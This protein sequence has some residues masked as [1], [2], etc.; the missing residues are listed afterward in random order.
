[1]KFK[2]I[3]GIIILS[4]LLINPLFAQNFSPPEAKKIPE[5]FVLHGHKRI[6]NYFWLRNK[7][8]PAV[9]DYLKAENEYVNSYMEDT[10]VLQKKLFEEFKAR[11]KKTD[12]SVPVKKGS[13][14]YYTR[15]EADKEYT[16]YCRKKD[17]MLNAEEVLLDLNKLS[18]KYDYFTLGV[19][20]VS[21]DHRF[22]A[23]SIDTDGSETHTLMI[24]DLQSGENL[25]EKIPNTYYSVEW[26]NDSKTIYYNVLDSAKRPF[27]LYRHRLGQNSKNDQLIYQED[28]A[29]Y[30]LNLYKTKSEKYIVISLGSLTT[31][32][33]HLLNANIPEASPK[34][35]QPR[36]K[37][38]EYSIVHWKEHFFILTNENAENYKILQ[39]PA[40]S[41]QKSNWKPFISHRNEVMLKE[42]EVF[43]NYLVMYERY[44]GLPHIR[45]HDLEKNE[46]F[47]IDFPE[48][49]YTYWQGSNPDI[50]SHFLRFNYTS[51]TTPK[52]VYDYDLKNRK[53]IIKKQRQIL[54]YE[55]DL[56]QTDRIFATADDGTKIPISLV[57]KKSLKKNNGNPLFL[58]AYGAYGSISDPWF[59]S[60]LISL[61]D[62]GF[63]YAIA[64]IRGGGEMGESWYKAG[65][66]LN[67]K[68]SFSD[69]IK[70]A[71]HLISSGYTSKEQLVIQGVSAGGLLMG[72]VTNMRP[73]LFKAVIAKVP[74]VDALNTM[75]DPSLPLTVI[76]YDE[77]GN[78]QEKKYYDYIKT[79]S[80]YDNIEKKQYPHMLVTAGLNDPRVSYWEPAKLVAKL[81]RYK[82]DNNILLFKTNMN[83]GHFDSSGRFGYLEDTAFDYAFYLKVLGMNSFKN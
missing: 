11:I 56:Y 10:K 78:P 77:W 79:Y 48:P 75:L 66:L 82:T 63:V 34:L 20:K 28:D 23:Y 15:T 67:K 71:E 81:R 38:I 26:A 59:E 5:E 9:I 27:Q 50:N 1:M 47:E 76:E 41:P 70:S 43:S 65:K 17:S 60:P 44:N 36:V 58:Y 61:M 32:E 37:D 12:Q 80:P 7:K 51:L 24:K 73:D 19:Y 6:D 45:V 54:N 25:A 14:F 57:Y 35:I 69:F 40:V 39:T 46:S 72:A 8:D 53:A 74:F 52:R 49:V 4:T 83:A 68:N 31:S 22:L 30:E 13:Y 2:L 21:P 62:R 64:H 29:S 55:P 18:Q 16:I 33:L 42:I 3:F